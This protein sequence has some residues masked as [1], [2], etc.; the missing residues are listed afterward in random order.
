MN[1]FL[2]SP[3]CEGACDITTAGPAHGTVGALGPRASRWPVTGSV[4]MAQLERSPISTVSGPVP[5]DVFRGN[6]SPDPVKVQQWIAAQAGQFQQPIANA[7]AAPTPAVVTPLGPGAGGAPTAPAANTAARPFAA[8]SPCPPGPAAGSE[9]FRFAAYYAQRQVQ[10]LI[11]KLQRPWAQAGTATTHRWP[12]GKDR[13]LMGDQPNRKH[14]MNPGSHPD[15]STYD[16]TRRLDVPQGTRVYLWAGKNFKGQRFGPYGPGRHNIPNVKSGL[17]TPDL[18]IDEMIRMALAQLKTLSCPANGCLINAGNYETHPAVVA[19]VQFLDR[20]IALYGNTSLARDMEMKKT[21]LLADLARGVIA[22]Q[23][24]CGGQQPVATP[25]PGNTD[26]KCGVGVTPLT[27]PQIQTLQQ[28][29]TAYRIGKTLPDGRLCVRIGYAPKPGQA[30]SAGS[31]V[32][33]AGGA[34]RTKLQ[35][36]CP[37]GNFYGE[38][39]TPEEAAC[40]AQGGRMQG[41]VNRRTQRLENLRCLRPGAGMIMQD[42]STLPTRAP[43]QAY[44]QQRVAPVRVPLDQLMSSQYSG[45]AQPGISPAGY[46]QQPAVPYFPPAAPVPQQA[47]QQMPQQGGLP[48]G[49]QQFPG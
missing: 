13:G 37:S 3:V 47:P 21:Q 14:K 31:G 26:E 39:L 35:G 15:I 16:R 49:F 32:T 45:G 12:D 6:G 46:P 19:F 42:V 24:V 17:V 22:S 18:D 8:V 7:A 11:L 2:P 4:S 43:G 33:N 20:V 29:G 34:R 10:D 38:C 36:P 41:R 40:V 25:G 9:Q 1:R 27:G 28:Q 48:A 30:G 5:F 23:S 44:S